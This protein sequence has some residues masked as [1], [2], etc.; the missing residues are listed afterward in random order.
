MFFSKNK[1][2]L[3]KIKLQLAMVENSDSTSLRAFKT[4]T[5]IEA[6][7][8]ING[9]K[10][11]IQEDIGWYYNDKSRNTLL[12]TYLDGEWDRLDMLVSDFNTQAGF[13]IIT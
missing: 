11:V 7:I 4:D 12:I 6:L 5:G 1:I 8:Q 10:S 2:K 13:T 9:I 3:E